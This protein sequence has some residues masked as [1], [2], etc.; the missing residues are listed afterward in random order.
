MTLD[1]QVLTTK[2]TVNEQVYARLKKMIAKRELPPGTP[3][4]LRPLAKQ[5]GVSNMP[6]IE[7]IRRLER[8]GLV[9]VVPK[10]GATVKVWS[11]TE[12]VE[13]FYIR[14]ALEK[15]A[16]R[17]FVL[18][19]R[20]RDK[21]KLMGLSRA[22]DHYAAADPPL[23]LE[24]DV[25][26]HLHIVR[27][28]GFR[29]LYALTEN[30]QIETTVLHGLAITRPETREEIETGCRSSIGCHEPLVEALKGTDPDAAEVAMCRHHDTFQWLIDRI[31][32]EAEAAQMWPVAERGA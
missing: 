22:F 18:R 5:L 30:S 2:L 8:D 10:L 1:Q 25:N 15:E 11:P 6:V 16:A 23:C 12:I 14:R 26:F 21:D 24:A 28:T 20:P 3:L 32:Q 27:S 7:A 29:R 17:L 13:A 31:E 19:A 4:V 9:T